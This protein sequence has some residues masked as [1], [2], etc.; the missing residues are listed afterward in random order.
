MCRKLLGKGAY[1]GEVKTVV[2]ARY[3]ISRRTVER[4]L[5]RARE[6]MRAEIGRDK[7][8]LQAES[9]EVYRSILMDEDAK[10]IEKIK[11][12]ERM[13]KLLGLEAPVKVASTDKEGND[14][15]TRE[16]RQAH[17]EA[18]LREQV[19][20]SEQAG[21]HGT[22]D[23]PGETASGAVETERS[24]AA[25]AEPPAANSGSVDDGGGTIAA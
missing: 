24:G 1:D 15:L 19:E 11:A 13:D 6:E 25:Q 16:Q 2:A 3:G 23:R 14:L 17:L 9:L 18:I 5:R 7:P 22:E 8:D 12:R 10:P 21:Q 4:Y 20:Q